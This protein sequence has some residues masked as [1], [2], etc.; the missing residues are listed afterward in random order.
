[1]VYLQSFLYTKLADDSKLRLK[2]N[3]LTAIDVSIDPT[4]SHAGR[5]YAVQNASNITS[6]QP[7][8]IVNQLSV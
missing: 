6:Y 5:W 2:Y 3:A 8:I 4:E 1:M 7:S